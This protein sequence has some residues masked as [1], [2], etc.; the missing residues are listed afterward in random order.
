M[1]KKERSSLLIAVFSMCHKD[2][3]ICTRVSC[4]GLLSSSSTGFWVS[5]VIDSLQIGSYRRL[6]TSQTW[7]W[8]DLHQRFMVLVLILSSSTGFWAPSSDWYSLARGK[9]EKNFNISKHGGVTDLPQ[10]SMVPVLISTSST[11]FQA[12]SEWL[13]LSCKMKAIEESNHLK[14]DG[15]TCNHNGGSGTSV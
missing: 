1:N 5:L 7:W 2:I 8:T 10:I 3:L 14:H 9:L 15:D 12:P 11:G 13:T 4:S 6:S